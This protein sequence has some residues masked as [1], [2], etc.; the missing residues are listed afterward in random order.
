VTLASQTEIVEL[1]YDLIDR[2]MPA[3]SKNE[4]PLTKYIYLGSDIGS[5]LNTANLEK[6]FNE[7]YKHTSEQ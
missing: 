2:Y 5:I 7:F 4:L 1:N 6:L 3:D